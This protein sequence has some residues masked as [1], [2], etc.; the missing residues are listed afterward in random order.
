MPGIPAPAGPGG[1]APGQ[2]G[3]RRPGGGGDG[4]PYPGAIASRETAELYGLQVLCPDISR[5]RDNTTR[6]MVIG[7][8][9]PQMG[10][11]FSLLFTIPHVAGSLARVVETIGKQGYNME[12]ASRAG[13]CPIRPG[14]TIFIRNWW[15]RRVRLC[16]KP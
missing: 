15:G 10:N 14:N 7:K 9:P 11:R 4:G 12:K 3:H 6:F 8:E 13:P 2:Y 5:E 16:W 1:G